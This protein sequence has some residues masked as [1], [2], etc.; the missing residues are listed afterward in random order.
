MMEAVKQNGTALQCAAAELKGDREIVME[1]VKQSG[2]ALEYASAELKGDQ[3]IV[4]EAVKQS[5]RALACASKELQG[6]RE[7]VTKAVQQNGKALLYTALKLRSDRNIVTE[8]V[9]QYG[10][11]LIYAS[12]ALKGDQEVVTEAVH[13]DR[14]ALAY[15]SAALR[16]G[17]LRR[18]LEH[19]IRSVFNV[20]KHTFI[21]TIL[22]GAKAALP[23]T[24]TAAADNGDDECGSGSA[25]NRP[26]LCDNSGCFLS[27]LRPSSLLPGPLST[28]IKRLIWM[29]AGVQ[30]GPKWAVI[31]GAHAAAAY[32]H[33]SQQIDL[34][35]SLDRRR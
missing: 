18:H 27:L 8:A 16:D 13:Q 7:F 17:G 2:W 6:D 31:E 21:A 9:K 1:A 12:A 32:A 25:S 14:H 23:P 22:F 11:A 24:P 15:A 10:K 29:Y 5:G 4:L 33:A 35:I 20:P 28:Q 19:L 26:R 30:S 3:E 34:L